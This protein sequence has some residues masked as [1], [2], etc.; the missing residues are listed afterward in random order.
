MNTASTYS[1]NRLGYYAQGQL[2]TLRFGTKDKSQELAK[3]EKESP[4]VDLFIQMARKPTVTIT[5]SEPDVA[6]RQEKLSAFKEWLKQTLPGL[7]ISVSKVEETPLGAV[8]FK[9]PGHGRY[10]NQPPVLLNAHYDIVAASGQSPDT[11]IDPVLTEENGEPW[12]ATNGKTS[13]G[14]DNKAGLAM[15]LDAVRRVTGNHPTQKTP[16]DHPPIELL[17]TPDEESTNN[18]LRPENF[19]PKMLESQTAIVVDAF[20]PMTVFRKMAGATIVNVSVERSQPG[21]HSGVN[22]HTLG[23]TVYDANAAAADLL[24]NRLPKWTVDAN[25]DNPGG[26]DTSI[27]WGKLQGATA[28]NAI[29]DKAVIGGNFRSFSPEKKA[30]VEAKIKDAVRQAEADYQKTDPHIQLK[31]SLMDKFPPWTNPSTFL[32]NIAKTVG[33]ALGQD[34]KDTG[35]PASAISNIIGNFKNKHG[36][37]IDTILMGPKIIGAHSGAERVNVN[38]MKQGADWLYGMIQEIGKQQE[39]KASNS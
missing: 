36:K 29:A 37:G 23:K 26:F 33:K 11:P 21:G 35:M 3:L 5:G 22:A 38:S 12:L 9:I 14:A 24:A 1:P 7:G 15:I 18:S 17:F 6:L 8:V 34:V 2:D 27:N 30:V 20:D 16:V 19:D 25:P 10:A 31:L 13:L 4:V 39:A 32:R 28:P